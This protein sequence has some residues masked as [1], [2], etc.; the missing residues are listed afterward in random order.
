FVTQPQ[1]GADAAAIA[2]PE[3]SADHGFL[4]ASTHRLKVV[5]Q[6]SF[7]APSQGMEPCCRRVRVWSAGWLRSSGGQGSKANFIDCW[8]LAR[9]SGLMWRSKP[10]VSSGPGTTTL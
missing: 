10:T 1:M 2:G 4:P 7:H 8:S 6:S 9:N 5:T 3:F